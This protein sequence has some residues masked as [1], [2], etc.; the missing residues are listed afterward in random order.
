M[1]CEPTADIHVASVQIG[2]SCRCHLTWKAATPLS[3]AWHATVIDGTL[4]LFLDGTINRPIAECRTEE[5][6]A[7]LELEIDKLTRGR[8][9]LR[10]LPE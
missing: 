1:K 4:D 10:D 2:P 5:V 9:H 8:S 6:V 7:E 3:V